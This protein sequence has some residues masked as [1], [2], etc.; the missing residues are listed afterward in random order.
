MGAAEMASSLGNTVKMMDIN[1]EIMER[2]KS[3][4]PRNVS[5]MYSSRAA[6][7]ECL[8]ISDV[9]INCVL[10]PKTRKDHLIYREDLK[11]MKPGAMIIDVACDDGGAVETC[12]STTHEDPVYYEE[13]ILHY[14]VDNIPSAFSKSASIRFSNDS[15]PYALAVANKGIK[16]ALKDD[17]HLR[18]G[19]TTFD[20]KLTLKETAEKFEVPWTDPEELIKQW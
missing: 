15:L 3:M 4:L 12:R 14:A 1:F 6:I 18:A 20:G 9:I 11:M 5:F 13:G 19:L 7:E 8:K 17:R 10:W 16:Q 2:A